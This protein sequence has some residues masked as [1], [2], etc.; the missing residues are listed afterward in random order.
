MNRRENDRN[1]RD[2]KEGMRDNAAK[3]NIGDVDELK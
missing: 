1:K 2:R 3:S